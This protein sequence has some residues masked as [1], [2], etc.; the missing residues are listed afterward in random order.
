MED[1]KDWSETPRKIIEMLEPDLDRWAIFDTGSHP[2]PYFNK[3]RIC[4]LGDAAHA[5]APHHGAGAGMCVEDA[6]TMA[7]LLAVC[8]TAADYEVAFSVFNDHRKERGQ[9]LVQSS[10]RTGNIYD[11]MDPDCGRDYD[12]ILKEL[13]WR[14]NTIWNIDTEK[15]LA[16][17]DNDLR[18][19]LSASARGQSSEHPWKAW[20]QARS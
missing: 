8:K 3:G 19:R 15:M 12:K 9:W 16:A 13:T 4:L 1:F 14:T 5:T 18:S 20:G 7:R 2:C 11:M 17:A 6:A 10:R